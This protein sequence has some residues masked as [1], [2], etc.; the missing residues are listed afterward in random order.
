MPSDVVASLYTGLIELERE[1]RVGQ[2]SL[3]RMAN[4]PGEVAEAY[5]SFLLGKTSKRDFEIAINKA[6]QEGASG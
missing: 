5:S 2:L 6:N 3:L 1:D 4:A